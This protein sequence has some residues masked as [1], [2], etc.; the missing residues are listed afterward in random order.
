[1]NDEPTE[2][3]E[4]GTK[5]WKNSEGQW[6]R[7]NDLPAIITLNG[8]HA[9]YKNDYHHR[10]ND[11]PAVMSSDGYYAWWKEDTKHR[12]NDLPAVVWKDGC[13]EWWVNGVYIKTKIC[14]KEEVEQYKKPFYQQAKFNIKF[15]RFEKLLK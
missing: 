6:H 2:I 9:W 8:Y 12:D 11:L 7:D 5:V 3:D 10:D 4:F 14:T 1:M 13:C 15:N